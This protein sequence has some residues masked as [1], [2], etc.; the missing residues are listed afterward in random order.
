MPDTVKQFDI[1]TMSHDDLIAYAKRSRIEKASLA[2]EVDSVVME[3]A[4]LKVK[5]ASL[6]TEVAKG[7]ALIAEMINDMNYKTLTGK[8]KGELPIDGN[9][10]HSKETTGGESKD[11]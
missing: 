5:V 4:Q 3:N 11:K 10:E 2:W 6:E 8:W 1:D 9:Q 7:D